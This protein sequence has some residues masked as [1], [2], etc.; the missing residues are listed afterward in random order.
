MHTCVHAFLPLNQ[1]KHALTEGRHTPGFLNLL[2]SIYITA[3]A[4]IVYAFSPLSH[5]LLKQ[6]HTGTCQVS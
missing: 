5:N 2:L 3:C 1:T 6:V 4:R